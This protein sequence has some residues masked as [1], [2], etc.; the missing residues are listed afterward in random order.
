MTHV[1]LSKKNTQMS[2]SL[3][4]RQFVDEPEL[5]THKCR[6][7][8]RWIIRPK[9][10]QR[11]NSRQRPRSSPINP[12]SRCA[13][14]GKNSLPRRRASFLFFAFATYLQVLKHKEVQNICNQVGIF[15][16]P[17]RVEKIS[18]CAT[19]RSS[20]TDPWRYFNPN[21]VESGT[22]Y[23]APTYLEVDDAERIQD[24]RMTKRLWDA[25]QRRRS[26]TVR[27]TPPVII[28]E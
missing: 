26:A 10:L 13:A 2:Q 16:F 3:F 17:R 11:E 12:H 27:P 18:R 9:R 15:P 28:H 21:Y 22:K 23:I 5:R 25:L 19:A 8:T 20:R 7:A 24:K 6:D 1:L 4:R 14:K